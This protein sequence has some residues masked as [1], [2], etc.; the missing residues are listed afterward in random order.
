MEFFSHPAVGFFFLNQEYGC[1]TGFHGGSDGKE[2]VYNTGD[3][4][5]I[6]G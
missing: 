2:S 4:G 5:S 6:P 1:L 3:Q